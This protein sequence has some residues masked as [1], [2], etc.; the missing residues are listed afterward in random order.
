MKLIVMAI[1]VALLRVEVATLK[2][3][4]IMIERKEVLQDD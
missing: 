4:T 1:K 3:I 2:T